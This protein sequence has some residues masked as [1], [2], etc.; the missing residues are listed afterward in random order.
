MR[1]KPEKGIAQRFRGFLPVVVDVE[2]AGFDAKKNALLEIAALPILMDEM[3]KV[4]P[5]ETIDCYVEPFPGSEL[6]PKAL[7]FTGIDPFHPFRMAK[8]EAE[9]LKIIFDPLSDYLEETRCSRAILVGH[10]PFF[11]LGFIHAASSRCGF[12][13]TPFHQFSTFDTAT[14][15]G[16]AFGQ[17]VLARAAQ[18]A[19]IQWNNSEAHSAVYDAERTAELFCH[20]INKWDR[21]DPP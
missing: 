6:D 5:G 4:V 19:G 15:G 10:N 13:K 18:A 1:N 12:S 2:T 3:G 20:I 11:D 16:L 8:P 14:L 21:V 9:A 7:E 17:T